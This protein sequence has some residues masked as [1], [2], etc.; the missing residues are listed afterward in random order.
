MSEESA[1]SPPALHP[2]L[3]FLVA[4]AAW[5]VPGLGH[6]LLRRWRRAIV[7][8][9]GVSVFALLGLSLGGYVFSLHTNDAFELL[10]FLSNLGAGAYY[11]IAKHLAHI[12]PDVSR[13]AGDYGTRFF[14]AAG[15]LNFLCVLDAVDIASGRKE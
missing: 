4:V 3:T 1:N 7:F 8:F 10:G 5:A 2:A 15:V 11:F 14:A 12:V 6:L 9:L 13:A